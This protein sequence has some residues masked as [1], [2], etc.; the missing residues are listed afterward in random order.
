VNWADEHLTV[1][2]L[3][4]CFEGIIPAEIATAAPDGTP[5]VTHLS[6]VHMVDD[7]HVALSNQF[8]SKTMQNLAANPRAC[9]CVVDPYT[10]DSYKLVVQYERTE[11]RGPLFERMRRDID[12]IAA[13]TGMQDVFKLKSADVYRVVSIQRVLAAV[14]DEMA[15][16]PPS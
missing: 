3:E 4:S 1:S 12:A 5:N 14:H 2:D 9:V 8:F 10:F 13:L 11:R 7:D 6:R 16:A 15:D